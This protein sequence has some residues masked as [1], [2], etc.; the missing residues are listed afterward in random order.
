MHEMSIIQSL[1]GQIAEHLP[2]EAHPQNVT[3]TVGSLEHL[4]TEVMQLAWDAAT[5]E[6]PLQ[7]TRLTIE[8][9][10][11]RVRCRSCDEEFAPL[12]AAYLVC[13]ECGI[14]RP[15]VLEGWGVTLKS[16]EA[17]RL[18]ASTMAEARA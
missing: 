7:N 14:A 9:V 17:T 13:P 3:I 6:S 11:I 10:A 16:I 2:A 5:Q 12:D 1:T 4:D 8:R 15:E 18:K